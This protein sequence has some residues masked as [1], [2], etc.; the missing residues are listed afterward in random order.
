M[1][2]LILFLPLLLAC[3]TQP[4]PTSTD[5][6]I[7]PD[8]KPTTFQ[9]EGFD[10]DSVPY[11]TTKQ[12]TEWVLPAKG[13]E[14]ASWS[15]AG[16]G[17]TDSIHS[18]WDRQR[19]GVRTIEP[20]H[21]DTMQRYD[22][23]VDAVDYLLRRAENE[24]I[25]IVNEGH[26]M[27]Q[28]RVFTT[29]LLRGL[30]DRGYRNFGLEAFFAPSDSLL[31]A[32][33]YPNVTMGFYTKEP[34][35][36]E[37]LREAARIGYRVFGY[38][39]AGTGS[40]KKREIGQAE[41]IQRYLDAHPDGK[42]LIHC[43]FD[44]ALEGEM[45]GA[46]EYAMAER[47]KQNTGI[48][49]LTVNQTDQ[50]ERSRRELEH[51][52]RQLVEVD[53]PTV[54]LDAGGEPLAK[55]RNGGYSDV[56][57]FHPRTSMDAARPAWMQYG[58]RRPVEVDLGKVPFAPPYLLFVHPLGEAVGEAVPYDLQEVDGPATTLVLAPGTYR[59]VAQSPTGEAVEASWKL[60]W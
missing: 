55:R 20:H 49:P 24:Q 46:W 23:A 6:P 8:F 30:Y 13:A 11:P 15:Y 34:R 12:I 36:G 35:F 9:V 25:L 51:P 54:F 17:K 2:Y 32:Q 5:D 59:L 57:V 31:A 40:P 14:Y 10:W 16:L 42:T 53:A 27:P 60:E 28:H 56:M 37:L 44:H 39:A 19:S 48:D 38:E 43:G 45:G 29:R 7:Q 4:T 18:V 41:N 50:S 22:R 21:R 52:Y 47:V 33:R 26:H 3:Q 58:D 1:R